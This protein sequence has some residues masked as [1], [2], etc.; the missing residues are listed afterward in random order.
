[1]VSAAPSQP[2]R[3]CDTPYAYA[4][5]ASHPY[6]P[7][8]SEPSALSALAI[9]ASAPGIVDGGSAGAPGANRSAAASGPAE[10]NRQ[11]RAFNS[12]G[13]GPGVNVGLVDGGAFRPVGA[14]E[15]PPSR[16]F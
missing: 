8:R 12:F 11:N 14:I 16:E 5:K 7:N 15:R 6:G 3:V 1:M 10:R 9:A 13:S 4:T 2:Y